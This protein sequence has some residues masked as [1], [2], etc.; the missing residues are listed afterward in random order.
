MKTNCVEARTAVLGVLLLAFLV[1]CGNGTSSGGPDATPPEVWKT[2]N[3]K[4][5]LVTGHR[6]ASGYLPEHTLASYTL[7]IEQ[8]ADFIEPDL[9]ATK[10]G[11]LIARHEPEISTTTDVG[12][13]PE[14][15]DRKTTKTVDGAPVEGFFASDF[16]LAEIKQLRAVQPRSYRPQEHNGKY[17]I[18]TLE[19]IIALAKQKSEETGRV[20]GIYPETKHPTYHADLGLPLEDKLLA[21]LEQAG[22][23][24]EGAKV[25]IQSFEVGNLQYLRQ[26]TSLP[27]VQLVDAD[28]VALDGKIKL[29]PPHDKPYD[30]AKQNDPRT[31]AD[32][33]TDEGLTFVATYADGVSP[34]KRYIVSV[35]GVDANGDGEADDVN[36]DGTVDDADRKALAPTDLVTRAHAKGL[37]VHTW[38]FRSE[39]MFLAEDYGATPAAE[40]E[41][42]YRLGIDGVF[43]DFP[44]EAVKARARLGL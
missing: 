13:K 41:V 38:T 7:A 15:A 32:L 24:G 1:G 39:G 12:S 9:V 28:G 18:P 34:W 37:F 30:F 14:F 19:E 31:F 21:A 25:I 6:G 17:E 40:Y 44:D 2:L 35:E 22:L 11:H 42:F 5:P 3:G 23:T 36:G 8:G 43:S 27:L 4:E 20:I 16:T 29:A 10:D 33:L 26:K